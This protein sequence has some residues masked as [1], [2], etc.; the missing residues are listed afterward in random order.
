[1][2]GGRNIMDRVQTMTGLIVKEVNIDVEDVYV[3]GDEF[4]EPRVE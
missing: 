2:A 1:M 4:S 3:P